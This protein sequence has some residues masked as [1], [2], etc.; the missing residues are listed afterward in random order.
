MAK[1]C[2]TNVLC[3]DVTARVSSWSYVLYLYATAT[4]LRF[5]YVPLPA[6]ETCIFTLCL[7]VAQWCKCLGDAQSVWDRALMMTN[8][9]FILKD[10]LKQFYKSIS[11][12]DIAT[13]KNIKSVAK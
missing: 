7:N 12:A 2:N 1:Y 3:L 8:I 9:L 6:S 13:N 4:F 10:L 11:D 5:T